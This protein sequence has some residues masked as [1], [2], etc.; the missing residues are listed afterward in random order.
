MQ[1]FWLLWEKEKEF[2]YTQSYMKF[3]VLDLKR[4]LSDFKRGVKVFHAFAKY[5]IPIKN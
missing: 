4:F 5:L 3:G 1:Q 2:D